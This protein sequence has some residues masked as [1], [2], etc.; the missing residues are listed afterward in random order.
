MAPTSPSLDPLGVD[1]G[2]IIVRPPP[3]SGTL[4][5]PSAAAEIEG[6]PEPAAEPMIP[7]EGADDYY[8]RARDLYTSERY[9]DALDQ[10]DSYLRLFPNSTNAADAQYWKAHSYFK[11]GQFDRAVD[12]FRRLELEYPSSGKVPIALHNMAV[13]QARLGEQ[14]G[15]IATF[16]KLIRIYPDDVVADMARDGLRKLQGSN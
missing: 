16:E 14:E 12:E 2:N 15:A 1:S 11:M 5:P 6:F 7:S 9:A 10:F 8:I 4:P 13:A 3:I